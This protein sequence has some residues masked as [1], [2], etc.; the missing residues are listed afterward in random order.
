VAIIANHRAKV[1]KWASQA[2][3]DLR[4]NG[5]ILSYD[6]SGTL[7]LKPDTITEPFRSLTRRLGIKLCFHDLRHFTATQLI[8]AKVDPVTVAGRLG[9]RDPSITRRV[10]S[11]QVEERDCEARR[12]IGTVLSG[13]D[14]FPSSLRASFRRCSTSRVSR[15]I[16]HLSMSLADAESPAS[17]TTF[18]QRTGPS[19]TM[20]L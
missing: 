16:R 4:P 6:P 20:T 1:E 18:T 11:A 7:P 12:I 2:K 10:Y 13:P 3:V 14:D 19:L 17:T 5:F 8:G 9:H 15:S